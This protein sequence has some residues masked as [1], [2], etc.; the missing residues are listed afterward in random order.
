MVRNGQHRSA[1]AVL[2]VLSY[3]RSIKEGGALLSLNKL[4]F[5]FDSKIL[6]TEVGNMEVIK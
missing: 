3:N 4:K 1:S 2:I 5:A 6:S